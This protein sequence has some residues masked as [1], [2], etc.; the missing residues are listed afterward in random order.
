[1]NAPKDGAPSPGTGEGLGVG[2]DPLSIRQQ[3][4]FKRQ[5]DSGE[6]G[7]RIHGNSAGLPSD[8]DWP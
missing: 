6:D 2:P 4:H 3:L 7:P 1:M 5:I 8:F